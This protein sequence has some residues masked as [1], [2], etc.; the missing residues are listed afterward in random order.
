MTKI[1]YISYLRVSTEGQRISG[2]GLEAQRRTVTDFLNGGSWELISEYVEA[3]SGR[4]RDRPQLEAALS[5][6]RIHNAILIVAKVDRLTR[7]S[8]FLHKL[9]EA[10]VEIRFCDLPEIVGPTGK[11]M[12]NQM[13]AVAE[14]E[15]GMISQRTKAAL[16]A[17]KVRGVKLGNPDNAT[18]EGRLKGTQ[19]ASRVR[20]ELANRRASD[21]APVIADIRESGAS[22]L[23][24]IA[25][26]LNR[27]DIPT[28]RGGKW[29][30]VQVSR[31]LDGVMRF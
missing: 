21:L 10:R 19:E 13:A 29:S 14:L 27:R 8:A 12:L 4:K 30:A 31:V 6:C 5:A 23:R 16:A 22:S 20:I 17:A 2:L 3:E 24:Q 11:F 25:A 28:A 18:A 26:E 7:S 15:A 1:R 9:L